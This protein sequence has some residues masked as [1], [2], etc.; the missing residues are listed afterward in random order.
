MD[1]LRDSYRTRCEFV[2]AFKSK[3]RKNSCCICY[4]GALAEIEKARPFYWDTQWEK[5]D[6][7]KSRE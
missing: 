2:E 1:A 4:E 6:E 3:M 7:K 5:I